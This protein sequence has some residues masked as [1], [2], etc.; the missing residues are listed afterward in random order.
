[1][2]PH[3]HKDAFN[4]ELVKQFLKFT[5]GQELQNSTKISVIWIKN[6]SN[7]VNKISNIKSM[8]IDI[9]LKDASN[10]HIAKLDKAR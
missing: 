3:S 5:N 8:M 7:T 6:L 4:K 9:K 2:Q 1:M 10:V